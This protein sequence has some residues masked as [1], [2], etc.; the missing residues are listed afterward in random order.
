M[1]DKYTNTVIKCVN[2]VVVY[3]Y[4]FIRLYTCYMLV[5]NVHFML[6][7]MSDMPIW[8]LMRTCRVELC[9]FSGLTCIQRTKCIKP[10]P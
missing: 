4:L 8:L 3:K 5:F 9:L 6:V 7:K 1:F 10:P 2:F